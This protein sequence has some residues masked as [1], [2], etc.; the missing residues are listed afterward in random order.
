AIEKEPLSEY[1]SRRARVAEQIK[2]SALILFG[3]TDSE[4]VKFKQ[5]D[6]F[7]YLTGFNEPDAV[8]IIDATGER[9]EETLFIRP[10]NP[11]EERWTGVTMPAG[12][13]G[14]RETG[15]AAVKVLSEMNSA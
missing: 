8:L 6:N 5:T 3:Q 12:A 7:Y 15:I 10:R 4:F 9:P 2:G 14:Q 1:A 11:S 13:E